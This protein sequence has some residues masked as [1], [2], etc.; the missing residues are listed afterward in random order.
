MHGLVFV[1]YCPFD[2][3][4]KDG[5]CFVFYFK[6]KYFFLIDHIL[7]ETICHFCFCLLFSNMYPKIKLMAKNWLDLCNFYSKVTFWI[8]VYENIFLFF[9]ADFE[10]FM[11]HNSIVKISEK[12]N[13]QNWLKICLQVTYPTDFCIIC[14]H[15]YYVK[16]WKYLI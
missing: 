16:K 9:F 1:Y 2:I 10:L 11:F 5:F 14:I 6:W 8:F 7:S 13:K 3:T 4:Q 12:L 15:F